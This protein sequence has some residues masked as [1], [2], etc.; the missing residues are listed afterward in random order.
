MAFMG[1]LNLGPNIRCKVALPDIR[2]WSEKNV[3][4]LG[5]RDDDVKAQVSSV[6]RPMGCMGT[7]SSE[8]CEI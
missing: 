1:V 5:P 8:N 6:T 3:K 2:V 4:M 7:C